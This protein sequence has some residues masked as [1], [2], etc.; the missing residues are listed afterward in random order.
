MLPSSGLFDAPP[1]P[2][3]LPLFITGSFLDLLDEV[4]WTCRDLGIAP[5]IPAIPASFC[6]IDWDSIEHT[7]SSSS[8]SVSV[9]SKGE[10]SFGQNTTLELVSISFAFSLD[11]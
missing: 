9:S 7:K 1:G 2:V 5:A 4:S 10:D 11:G 8:W 3:T 6:N